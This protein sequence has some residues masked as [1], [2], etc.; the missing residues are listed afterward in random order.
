MPQQD[1]FKENAPK[2]Q[3]APPPS[4]DWFSANAPGVRQPTPQQAQ[5]QP[6]AAPKQPGGIMDMI[7]NDPFVSVLIGGAKGAMETVGTL[8]NAARKYIPGVAAADE[9]IGSVP[10]NTAPSNTMQSVGKT[11]ERVA[12]FMLG[13]AATA[14]AK[15]G[16]AAK[17]G[18]GIVRGL[19][20]AG[21][22]GVAAAGVTAAQGEP[23]N[24]V[25]AGEIAAGLNLIVPPTVNAAGRGIRSLVKLNPQERA[26]VEYAAKENIPVRASTATGNRVIGGTESATQHIPFFAGRGQALA[27]RTEE[28]LTNKSA[29]LAARAGGTLSKETAG[30]SVIAGLEKK[31]EGLNKL[32]DAAY[33][34]VRSKAGKVMVNIAPVKAQ[35]APLLEELEAQIPEAQRQM[36]P[37]FSALRNIMNTADSVPLTKAMNDLSAIQYISRTDLPLLRSKAQGIAAAVT[38]PL[39]EAVDTAAK[40]AGAFDALNSGRLL[41]RQK[42]EIGELLSAI[43]DREPVRLVE[44]LTAQGDRSIQTLREITTAAPQ[45]AK[46]VG[47]STLQGI[48]DT[49]TNEGTFKGARAFAQWSKIGSETKQLLFKPDHIDDLNKFFQLAK[50]EAKDFNPSGSGKLATLTATAA[51]ALAHPGG[52]AAGIIGAH[53]VTRLLYKPNWAKLVIS[54]MQ[55]SPRAQSAPLITRALSSAIVQAELEQR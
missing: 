46:D 22:E 47:A 43:K 39:R 40:R 4:D 45:V 24:A 37:A 25:R 44:S 13:G 51:I 53:V 50:M 48:F 2:P 1:W 33:S 28:A 36:S 10:I 21:L 34:M 41:T 15:A 23:Q 49:A 20:N 6:T 3:Q 11:A 8:G 5:Q 19:A 31:V 18:S 30:A 12:E 7:A 52:A 42:Y 16:I 17:T 54:A 27:Q 35:L 14:P 55:T 26:A 29:D 32:A 38:R 9:A